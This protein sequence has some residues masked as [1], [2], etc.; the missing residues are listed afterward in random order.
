[1]RY[2]L[3]LALIA[4]SGCGKTMLQLGDDETRE[5]CRF[6]V[7]DESPLVISAQQI[8]DCVGDIKIVIIDISIPNS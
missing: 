4:L 1:M 5:E 7:S 8:R 3:L 6:Y 2:A